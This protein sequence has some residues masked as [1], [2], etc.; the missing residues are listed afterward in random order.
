M[1]GEAAARKMQQR[2]DVSEELC[3]EQGA[4]AKQAGTRVRALESDKT[5]LLVERDEARGALEQEKARVAKLMASAGAA[6]ERETA[7]AAERD[8]LRD[9]LSTA[10]A[11]RDAASGEVSSLKENVA[12]LR[13]QVHLGGERAQQSAMRIAELM[14]RLERADEAADFAAF[15]ARADLKEASDTCAAARAEENVLRAKLGEA[16]GLVEELQR[17]ADRPEEQVV[18]LRAL[19]D[20]DLV[21]DEAGEGG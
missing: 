16:S 11:G 10:L 20:V 4:A 14:T 15:K 18:V 7:L 5:T 21:H 2:L 12:A 8:G 17:R 13:E 3:G 1:A 9:Q 19:Q 6:S